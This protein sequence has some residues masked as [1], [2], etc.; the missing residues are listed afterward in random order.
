[1][2]RKI[3]SFGDGGRTEALVL[4]IEWDSLDKGSLSWR[5]SQEVWAI[6]LPESQKEVEVWGLLEE[7]A[8][9][10]EEYL[11]LL[12]QLIYGTPEWIRV[13]K[14]LTI[15][16]KTFRPLRVLLH[17]VPSESTEYISVWNLLKEEAEDPEELQWICGTLTTG[18]PEHGE[19]VTRYQD[20][21]RERQC[22]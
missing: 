16:A 3:K 8:E 5:Q 19:A 12:D 22:F 13:F 11:W 4:L 15:K 9:S 17:R 20:K 10:F 14:V 7:T 18:T 1:M 2:K 6:V 21:I